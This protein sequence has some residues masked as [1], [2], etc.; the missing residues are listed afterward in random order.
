MGRQDDDRA[1]LTSATQI[2][3]HFPNCLKMVLLLK[4]ERG[5]SQQLFFRYL[6][7]E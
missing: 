2:H 4:L 3:V 5:A 1:K 6:K 7:R